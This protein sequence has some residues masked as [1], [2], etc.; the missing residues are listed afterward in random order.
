VTHAH[1]VQRIDALLV[2]D[3]G[4]IEASRALIGDVLRECRE[5]LTREMPAACDA[6]QVPGGCQR[7]DCA[8][9]KTGVYAA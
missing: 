3:E 5:A 4:R 9:C 2:L 8:V 7:Q 6:L 1:L